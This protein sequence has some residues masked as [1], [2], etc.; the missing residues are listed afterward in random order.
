MNILGL[1]IGATKIYYLVF[2]AGTKKIIFEN[3]KKHRLKTKFFFKKEILDILEETKKYRIRKIGV[4]I[5]GLIKNGILIYSP[6]FKE[7]KNLNLNK[8]FPK[9]TKVIF[10]NDANS[11]ALAESV[12]GVGK[13]KD[14]TSLIG[15]TLGSGL[16]GGIIIKQG[17]IA[18]YNGA[19]N[20]AGEI[21]H[22]IIQLITNN[23][24]QTT[25][26]AQQAI[27]TESLCSEKFFKQKRLNPKNE[28]IKAKEGDKQSLKVYEKFG[29]NLGILSAN[30]INILDPNIIVFGGGISSAFDL[31][32]PSLKET[33]QKFIVNPKN[34]TKFLKSK[35]G[36]KSVALG[37][38]LKCLK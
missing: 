36:K 19:F 26:N 33:A 30:L 23:K 22:I 27:E 14:F 9:K 32:F 15:L 21:G 20:G 8:I 13:K 11:F 5:A 6:N 1:D 25:D 10:E 2:N 7:I 17:K 24:Q 35:L 4:G 37:A 16:G 31:F 29:Q 18:V 34:Q 12:L 38:V 3:E 28:E